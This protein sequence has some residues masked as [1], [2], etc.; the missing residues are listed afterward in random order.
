[1]TQLWW[2]L[3]CSAGLFVAACF[4]LI[5]YAAVVVGSRYDADL[6]GRNE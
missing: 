4:A 2:I 6:N 3:G 1:M 5:V